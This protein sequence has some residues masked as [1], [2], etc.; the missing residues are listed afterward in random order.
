MTANIYARKIVATEEGWRE[1]P[2]YDTEGYPTVGYG[3]KVGSKGAPLPEFRLPQQAGEAWLDALIAELLQ[4]I[5]L[6][7]RGLC[8]V[9]EA[10]LLSMAY[11]MGVTGLLGFAKMLNA[12]DRRDHVE[13][14]SQMLDSRWARQTPARAH[15]H[16]EMMR[17]GKLLD[18]YK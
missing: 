17:S 10:V 6:T 1:T 13:A 18:Y 14:S 2:Y 15:R 12:L 3:F 8:T 4:D 7:S 9:R 11:Q 16:A 5:N